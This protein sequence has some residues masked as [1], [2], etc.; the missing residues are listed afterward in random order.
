MTNSPSSIVTVGEAER[1]IVLPDR[2][3]IVQPEPVQSLKR[4]S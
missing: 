1:E 2:K 3:S 4:Q